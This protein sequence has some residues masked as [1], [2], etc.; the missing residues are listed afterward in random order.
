MQVTKRARPTRLI[1]DNDPARGRIADQCRS[2][3]VLASIE[4]EVF[5]IHSWISDL[6]VTLTGAGRHEGRAP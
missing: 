5:I 2:G 3:G 6:T 1:P 4:V